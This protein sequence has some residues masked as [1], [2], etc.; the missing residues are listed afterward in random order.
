[1]WGFLFAD[2]SSDEDD[3][4]SPSWR[5]TD[6]ALWNN[7]C[8]ETGSKIQGHGGHFF[9]FCLPSVLLGCFSS[10]FRTL[11]GWNKAGSHCSCFKIE[12]GK[13]QISNLSR[14]QDFASSAEVQDWKDTSHST[15][16]K[17]KLQ[18][19]VWFSHCLKITSVLYLII[20]AN[21]VGAIK[22]SDTNPFNGIFGLNYWRFE[23]LACLLA[24][25]NLTTIRN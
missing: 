18:T 24:N 5:L 4:G 1:M 22:R 14:F 2:R 7:R 8:G 11:G 13:K 23:P 9:F 25:A 15:G 10:G 21:K 12:G 16:V 17:F 19:W 6:V 3:K 20:E